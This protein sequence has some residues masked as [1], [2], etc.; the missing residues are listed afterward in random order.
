[1][2]DTGPCFPEPRVATDG[3]LSYRKIQIFLRVDKP[4]LVSIYALP[5]QFKCFL[6][7]DNTMFK[8]RI[9]VIKTHRTLT[10]SFKGTLCSSSIKKYVSYKWISWLMVCQA[11]GLCSHRCISNLSSE[12]ICFAISSPTSLVLKVK[13]QYTKAFWICSA[14]TILNSFYQKTAWST[15]RLCAWL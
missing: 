12:R 2:A 15:T 5:K 14:L 1:M 8:H 10:V 6:S 13:L 4:F 3:K 11:G 9:V 7:T